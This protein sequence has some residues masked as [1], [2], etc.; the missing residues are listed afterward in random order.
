VTRSASTADTLGSTGRNR[1]RWRA[2]LPLRHREYRLLFGFPRRFH[3]LDRHA[4]VM[5][6]RFSPS[7]TAPRRCRRSAPV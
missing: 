3:L 4:N 7:M 2:L 1:A 6:F 5:V